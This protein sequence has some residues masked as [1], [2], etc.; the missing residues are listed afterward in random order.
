MSK[1][2]TE[3]RKAGEVDPSLIVLAPTTQAT[4][5]ALKSRKRG[6]TLRTEI[7]KGRNCKHNALYWSRLHWLCR[8]N[9]R[10][11]K[12]WPTKDGLSDALKK[13]I[14]G[15]EEIIEHSIVTKP[16]GSTVAKKS[17]REIAKHINFETMSQEDFA[18][19]FDAVFLL[20]DE[21][22]GAIPWDEVD[23]TQKTISD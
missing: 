22:I 13:K 6:D 23:F 17:T 21:L 19:Y 5:D 15:A 3:V 14:L 2:Y 12:L 10:I 20:L 8:N 16:D 18:E 1:L 4:V 7:K 9:E 11:E